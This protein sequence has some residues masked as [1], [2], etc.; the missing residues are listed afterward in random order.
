MWPSCQSPYIS[1]PTAQ[2]R[3]PNGRVRPFV[4]R[5][6]PI[7]VDGAPFAYSTRSAAERGSPRPVLTATYGSAPIM[8][9]RSMN[10]WSPTSFASTPFHAGFFR[11]GR[12]SGSPTPSLQ[13]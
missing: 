5:C 12:R 3:T 8:P 6:F 7:A 4:A 1:L 10:S 13:S 2:S 11:G 9:M